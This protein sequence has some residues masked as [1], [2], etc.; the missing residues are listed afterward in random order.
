MSFLFLSQSFLW[1]VN[2]FYWLLF[3]GP[4]FSST[5]FSQL[6][7]CFQLHWFLFVTVSFLLVASGLPYSYFSSSWGRN[8]ECWFEIFFFS[9]VIM[10]KV[11]NFSSSCIPHVL[12]NCASIFTVLCISFISFQTSSLTYGLPADAAAVSLSRVR[13]CATPWTA[14][15]QAPRP[16]DSP[17]KGTGVACHCLLRGLPRRALFNF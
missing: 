2:Q 12:V 4:A 9:K 13:L 17:G 16:W 15:H 5:D 7:S 8:L 3:K 1:E 10:Y 14:A 11:I 6:L